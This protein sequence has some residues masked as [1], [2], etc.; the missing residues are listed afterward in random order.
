MR[1]LQKTMRNFGSSMTSAGKALTIGVTAPVVAMG[2]VGVREL[3]A[4]QQATAQTNAEIKSTGGVAGITAS[5]VENLSSKLMQMSGID[6][7]VIQGGA[8]ILLTF[9]DIKKQ[10]G[11]FDA[12]T[13]AAL[14]LSV[15]FGKDLNSTSV[16]V[17]KALQDPVKGVTALTRVGVSFSQ[18]QKDTIKRLVE[19]GDKAKAQ[20]LILRELASEVGG[21]AKAYGTTAAGAVGRLREQFS[22]I[23]AQMVTF[24][25]PAFQTLAGYLQRGMTWFEGLSAAT[26]KWVGIGLLVG[27]AI[28]P[29]LI[30]LGSFVTVGQ[31]LLPL[32]IGI[33]APMLGVGAAVVALGAALVIGY[34][35]SEKFR[36]VVNRSFRQVAA[37]VVEGTASMRQTIMTWVAWARA[38]WAKWGADI[39]R[40][41][42]PALGAAVTI[43]ST[44]LANMRDVWLGVLA[45]LR[46]DWKTAWDKLQAI[47]GRSVKA[48]ETV[49]KA[50]G[51]TL[52]RA[53]AAIGPA[54]WELNVKFYSWGVKLGERL[55]SGLVDTVKGGAKKLGSAA[56]DA[57]GSAL[58]SAADAILPGRSKRG[59]KRPVG[60]SGVSV[61]GGLFGANPTSQSVLQYT[62]LASS[63]PYS[64][65]SN[66]DGTESLSTNAAVVSFLTAR[67]AENQKQLDAKLRQ[68][69]AAFGQR[70]NLKKQY[71]NLKR[72]AARQKGKARASTLASMQKK[73]EAID[74]LNGQIETLDMEILA[75]GGSIQADT[76]ALVPPDIDTTPDSQGETSGVTGGSASTGSDLL[77]GG[78]A[79][80]AANDTSSSMWNP[81]GLTSQSAISAL[82]SSV[83]RAM[84][85]QVVVNASS[86]D[87]EAIARR[88]SFILGGTRLRAGGGV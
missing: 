32:L 6:D 42:G 12:A 86:A 33:T 63:S 18:K 40:I 55:V 11:V 5:H 75:L 58:D 64:V 16:M 53:A 21:S 25:L 36:E 46:G 51:K 14:D 73:L 79:F 45:L 77:G 29:I 72:V 57:A 26:K 85:P 69:K 59:G 15:A 27:A 3:N 24:L 88:V 44:N 20:K 41:V 49:L 68:R 70:E 28:G 19:T 87:A 82:A 30:G 62:S 4:M 1:R 67:V 50:A 34:T 9:K 65:T 31:A 23:A 47:V 81:I 60:P 80:G 7:Q 10:G 35:K 48:A 13:T 43:I 8:N 84:G 2:A 37:A 78:S 22:G 71:Q 56:A 76:E 39:K 52:V 66:G 54:L 38:A 83:N 17:G 61:L 74:A